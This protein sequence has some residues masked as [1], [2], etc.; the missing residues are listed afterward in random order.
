MSNVISKKNATHYS[1]G[2]NC[3]GWHLAKTPNL[4]VI[5]ERVPQDSGEAKHYHSVAEQFFFILE[6]EAVIDINEQTFTLTAGEGIHIA[7]GSPH[8]LFN[9]QEQDLVFLVVSTP[10]SH[11]D[12]V[13]L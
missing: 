9:M 13:V 5:Q 11:G 1:W 10:P 6:G 7:P 4:S 8:M 12:K 2:L 3:D